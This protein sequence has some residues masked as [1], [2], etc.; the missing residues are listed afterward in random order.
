MI[1]SAILCVN[2]QAIPTDYWQ[3]IKD[4]AKNEGICED[5]APD[6]VYHFGST[7]GR[8]LQEM[9]FRHTA[10]WDTN[11]GWLIARLPLSS[12]AQLLEYSAC[13]KLRVTVS[14]TVQLR[15]GDLTNNTY[16][17][18]FTGS[19]WLRRNASSP[20]SPHTPFLLSDTGP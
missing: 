3:M 20:A 19:L 10:N 18:V 1:N 5:Q 11:L 16:S 17:H 12:G 2:S 7:N 13:S 4:P 15:P 8:L 14:K 9:Q 6:V